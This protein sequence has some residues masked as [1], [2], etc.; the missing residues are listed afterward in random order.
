MDL[1]AGSTI[2]FSSGAYD[3]GSERGRYSISET[4]DS[5][6]AGGVTPTQCRLLADFV[7]KVS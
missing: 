4:G 5:V 3:H 6:A 7:A 2:E 1:P